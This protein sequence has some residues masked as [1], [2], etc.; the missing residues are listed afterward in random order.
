[1]DARPLGERT[2]QTPRMPPGHGDRPVGGDLRP[3]KREVLHDA[4][5]QGLKP[6]AAVVVERVV[7]LRRGG[8]LHDLRVGPLRLRVEAPQPGQLVRIEGEPGQDRLLH[9]PHERDLASGD[10]VGALRAAA[11]IA[12]AG[13]P[14][15]A[16][17]APVVGVLVGRPPAPNVGVVAGEVHLLEVVVP[18]GGGQRADGAV[19]A[20]GR[21]SV[22]V[23]G[24]EGFLPVGGPGADAL[25]GATGLVHGMDVLEQ[26]GLKLDTALVDADG[27]AHDARVR[28]HLLVLGLV[29]V[30]LGDAVD[31]VEQAEELHEADGAAHGVARDAETALSG[32]ALGARVG[33]LPLRE[34]FPDEGDE[35]LVVGRDEAHEV[36]HLVEEA[37][38]VGAAREA[39]QVDLGARLPAACEEAIA[40]DDVLVEG[41]RECGVKDFVRGEVA[42][43]A[44]GEVGECAWCDVCSY[45][46]WSSLVIDMGQSTGKNK[47]YAGSSN[48][49]QLVFFRLI[50][51]RTY[52]VSPWCDPACER[53]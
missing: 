37:C 13:A 32:A 34:G 46:G 43:G 47:S 19:A 10:V 42:E 6:L 36:E 9:H 52:I 11:A 45:A 48:L 27:V 35:L 7:H 41:R 1:M 3:L 14:A 30:E 5:E 25:G 44:E 21:A 24:G 49:N 26:D 8:R 12:A 29:A 17:L 51:E 2:A 22:A 28:L 23:L 15:L 33:E 38:G 40:A 4:P 16:A 31:G 18:L 53:S 20:A 39:E 50:D